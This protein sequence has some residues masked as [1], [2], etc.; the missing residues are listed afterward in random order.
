MNPSALFRILLRLLP[1]ALAAAGI[2]ALAGAFLA[3]GAAEHVEIPAWMPT[4]VGICFAIPAIALGFISLRSVWYTTREGFT[5]NWLLL[6]PGAF[7][8]LL[9]IAV[10][11]GL[12]A[13]IADPATYDNLRDADGT[14]NTSPSGFLFIGLFAAIVL[15]CGVALPVALYGNGV[16]PDV[17]TKFDRAPDEYDAMADLL[18][19][20]PGPRRQA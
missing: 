11:A 18:K 13:V 17:R 4:F 19:G 16:T 10:V 9:A 7:A 5:P 20:R 12:A 15:A 3:W 1:A 8:L 6:I 2:A 14:I